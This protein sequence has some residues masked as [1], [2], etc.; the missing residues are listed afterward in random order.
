M[1]GK[2]K[3]GPRK[4]TV[5][6]QAELC[7]WLLAGNYLETAA[8]LVG[9][10]ADTVR[11][12]IRRGLKEGSGKYHSL[13]MAVRK[14]EAEA[15]AS[16]VERIRAAGRRGIW[17]ADAWFLE[18]KFPQQWG[19]WERVTVEDVGGQKEARDVMRDKRV[20]DLLDRAASELDLA[21]QSSGDS[22]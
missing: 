20:R 10:P 2:R 22:E 15:A 14:S 3:R 4:L 7:G 21:G 11:A 18:R 8:A 13:A 19:R 17:K 6:V 9:L 1:A 12:W 5:D 16:S